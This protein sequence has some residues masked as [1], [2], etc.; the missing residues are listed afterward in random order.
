M[1]RQQR[2]AD[3]ARRKME[4]NAARVRQAREVRTELVEA[5]AQA[6]QNLEGFRLI[7]FAAARN[8][9]RMLVRKEDIDALGEN[10]K[11]EFVTRENGDVV[12][13]FK[14]GA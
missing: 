13:E 10:D 12:V 8:A 4:N 7:L 11:L 9:G 3:E 2:R 14:A 1:N 5:Q 6:I